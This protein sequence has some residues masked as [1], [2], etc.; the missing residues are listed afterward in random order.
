MAA[1]QRWK[2]CRCASLHHVTIPHQIQTR[3]TYHIIATPLSAVCLQGHLLKLVG[4][5]DPAVLQAYMDIDA[6]R[7]QRAMGSMM[8]A[9]GGGLGGD[10]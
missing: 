6:A 8:K 9:Q 10:S 1:Q 5:R 4:D 7:A 3:N 2:S